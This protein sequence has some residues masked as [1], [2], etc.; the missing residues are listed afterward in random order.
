MK[1]T[2]GE[3]F[4]VINDTIATTRRI[5]HD[6]LPPTLAN[7]GLQAALE[8]F[9][10]GFRRTDALEIAF[11]IMQ[12]D[13]QSADKQVELGFFRT[14]QELVNNSI[15]HGKAARIDLRLW[16]SPTGIRLEYLDDGV[17]FDMDDDRF[18]NG[19]GMQ[20]IESRMKMFDASYQFT[21]APGKGVKFRA[22]YNYPL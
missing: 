2:A 19:L 12:N 21:S 17:G 7:F 1:E 11:E 4:S 16:H 10:E 8:E 15:K 22:Q 18:R 3:I 13:P 6:L 5:S 9:C 14:V 20:N